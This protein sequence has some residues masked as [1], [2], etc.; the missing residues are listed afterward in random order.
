MRELKTNQDI[1]D[2]NAGKIHVC[3]LHPA[4]G[5]HGLNL[6]KGGN[7]LVWF[8][9]TWSLE[10]YQQLSKRLHRQ[11]QT[12]KVIMHKL[13]A[14]GTIDER[15]LNAQSDKAAKQDTLMEAVKSII[16]KH[17]GKPKRLR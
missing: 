2:W 11:G 6:Q 7:T 15:V 8:G 13:V 1:E 9:H 5:G 3:L 14:S 4:S 10:L 16:K 12:S 17:H